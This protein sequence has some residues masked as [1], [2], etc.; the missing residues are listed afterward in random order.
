MARQSLGLVLQHIRT[1]VG[2]TAGLVSS[3]GKLLERFVMLRDEAAFAALVEEYGPMVLRVCRAVLR[4]GHEAEDASQATFLVLA[5]RAGSLD[6]R[7]PLGGWL[8]AV[9]ARIAAKARANVA[10]RRRHER[11]A[12]NLLRGEPAKTSDPEQQA[13]LHEELQRLPDKYRV[14]LVL[15]YLQ[16]KTHEQ[17]ARELGRPVGSMSWYLGQ[18]VEL[19]RKRLIRRGMTVAMS[20]LVTMLVGPA[21]GAMPAALLES[22]VRA[23]V[24]IAGGKT[25]GDAAVSATAASLARGACLGLA[26]TRLKIAAVVALAICV[27]S[28][29]V[30]GMLLQGKPAAPPANREAQASNWM[31]SGPDPDPLPPG[32]IARLGSTR[33]RPGNPISSVAFS[34]DGKTLVSGNWGASIHFWDVATGKELRRIAQDQRGLRSI[35][36]PMAGSLL[37]QG[38]TTR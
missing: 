12:M 5:R 32:A 34:P 9:A 1:L 31:P 37:R 35:W 38:A 20:V 8:H 26:M 4:D 2:G 18:G 11:E 7:R 14:P 10:K 27:V 36:Q 28:A 29:G 22:T 19:L 3:D 6:C 13:L 23:A 17:A 16:G 30:A 33:L 25:V 15:C 24:L 21:S